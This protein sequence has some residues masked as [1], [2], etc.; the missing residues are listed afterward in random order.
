MGNL[1]VNSSDSGV[2]PRSL[3][4]RREPTT[5]SSR[6]ADSQLL[7]GDASVV[8]AIG[9][10]LERLP[11]AA[12]AV[13]VLAAEQQPLSEAPGASVHW[14]EDLRAAV[15]QVEV[16]AGT[17]HVFLHGE[18]SDV[19]DVRRHLVLERGVPREGQSISGYWKQQR[20]EEGSRLQGRVESARRGGRPRGRRAEPGHHRRS[21]IKDC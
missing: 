2:T 10:T 17:P 12:V 11:D 6:R 18:A 1:R 14:V 21:R 7:I 3:T 20:T 19:R 8:P 13:V 9:A 5:K 4:F 15:A 16:P